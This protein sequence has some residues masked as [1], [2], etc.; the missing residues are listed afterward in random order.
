MSHKR[1]L[2]IDDDE[3]IQLIVKFG[4]DIAAGWEV[5]AASAGNLGIEI[6]KRELPDAILLDVMMPGIDGVTTCRA[7]QT[8]RITANIPVILMTASIQTAQS[9]RF[10]DLGISGIITKPFNS[11]DLPAQI[12]KI[13]HW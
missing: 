2:I 7:L 6:A 10:H 13:L 12:S 1:L 11:L 4:I 8:D 9:S 5:I 3:A